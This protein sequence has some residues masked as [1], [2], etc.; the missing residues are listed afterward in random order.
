MC[1]F[2]V[3]AQGLILLHHEKKYV[4]CRTV[5]SKWVFEVMIIFFYKSGSWELAYMF[6]LRT[7]VVLWGF[8]LHS[9]L[10]EVGE[11][12][13][14]KRSAWLSI[15]KVV[16]H[17]TLFCR[18]VLLLRNNK[19]NVKLSR[20]FAR[21][22]AVIA[23][24]LEVATPTIYLYMI[25]AEENKVSCNNSPAESLHGFIEIS[26]APFISLLDTIALIVNYN[27]SGRICV[28]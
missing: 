3:D 10:H 20:R 14:T 7:F 28:L 9:P 15:R 22:E 6:Y 17:I 26:K 25:F 19:K 2:R 5:Q 18:T 13:R 16:H 24:K 8:I 1:I 21:G 27:M 12:C 11:N 4:R 23:R